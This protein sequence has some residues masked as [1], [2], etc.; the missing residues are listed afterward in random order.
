MFG[1]RPV[2]QTSPTAPRGREYQIFDQNSQQTAAA[3]LAP[4]DEAALARLLQ[5]QR[6]H[7]DDPYGVR[8]ANGVEVI[9]IDIPM[10]QNRAQTSPNG[11][12]KIIDGLGRELFVFL[13]ANNTRAF[14]IDFADMWARETNFDGNYQV[15]PAEETA[16]APTPDQQQGGLIDV[17]PGST[18]DLARQ[19]ATP[20][21]FTGAWKVVVS[22][23]GEEVYRFSG[24]GNSQAD[25]NRVA[26][27]WAQRARFDDPI[28]V[29]PIMS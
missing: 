22:S 26:T 11:R 15:E 25:A 13:P 29:F 9:D 19:R 1:I 20:G 12:W 5:Y 28:E 4:S 7:P 2:G 10:V 16:P 8:T 14:A 18:T 21:T 17:V 27:Q 24:I 23:T 6:S 3:F